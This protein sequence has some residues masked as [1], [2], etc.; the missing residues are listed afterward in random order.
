MP[1]QVYNDDRMAKSFLAF[2]HPIVIIYT[3]G[4]DVNTNL[5]ALPGKAHA[6]VAFPVPGHAG[7]GAASAPHVFA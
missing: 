6:G 1:Q 5:H 3:S 4:G 2:R 7:T